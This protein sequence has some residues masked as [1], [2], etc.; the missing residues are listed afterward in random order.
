MP[1]AFGP[2]GF[3]A[4]GYSNEYPG[5]F[6]E[7]MVL[8]EPMLLEVPNG[9][10]PERAALT[11][12]MAVG[13]HA[14]QKAGLAGDEVPVVIGCGPVGLAV[15]ASLRL[16]G[17]GPIIAA[18][19]SPVRRELAERLGADEIVD[20]AAG[21]PY[22]KWEEIAVPPGVDLANPVVALLAG[23]QSR[24]C[25]IFE[26]VGVP[27]L[28]QQILEGAPRGARIVVA[29]VCM[30]SDRIEPIFGIHKELSIQFALAYSPEEFA[31]TLAHIAEGRIDVDPLITGR[32]GVDEVAAAFEELA[33][34]ERHAKIVVEPWR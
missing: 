19:F 33:S 23:T 9:L 7:L 18:D 17:I 32:I 6:G 34:P 2:Q 1:F 3:G 28:I 4:V 26:C 27:G 31:A 29:G 30:E 16:A 22:A 15:I 12:P 25:V 5:G 20:P 24:P 11:E 21:S 13:H 8:N 14:V 10:D